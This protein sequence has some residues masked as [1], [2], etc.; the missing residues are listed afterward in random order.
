MLREMQP[1]GVGPVKRV[2]NYLSELEPQEKRARGWL[3][4]LSV[5]PGHFVSTVYILLFF[6]YISTINL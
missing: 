6:I 3:F 5:T 2:L 4:N 1:V